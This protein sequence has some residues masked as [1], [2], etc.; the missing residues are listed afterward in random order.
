ML[1]ELVS[2]VSPQLDSWNWQLVFALLE[3]PVVALR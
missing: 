2:A 3:A 1:Q